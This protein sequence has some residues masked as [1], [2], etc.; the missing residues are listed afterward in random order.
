MSLSRV[1]PHTGKLSGL[2]VASAIALMAGAANAITL[3][4][5]TD[6]NV[7]AGSILGPGITIVGTPTFTGGSNQAATFTGGINPVGF[8]TGIVLMTGDVADIPGPNSTNSS[9]ET[10]GLGGSG[11][12]ADPSVGLAGAGEA[13]L[14]A[15]V[16]TDTHDAAV[17]QFD[18]M[19][20][21]GGGGDLFFNYVFASEEY[22]DF[23]GSSFNDA[24][25]LFVD[26]MNIALLPAPCS[27]AVTINNVNG[28]TNAACYR[29]NV[30]NTNGYPNLGLDTAF[31]GLT[32]V[33]TAS[34]TGLSAG[35]HTIKFAVADTSDE[36]LDSG[37]FIQAGTFANEEIPSTPPTTQIP[38]PGAM[39][40]FAFGLAGLGFARRRRTS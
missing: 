20:T 9:P 38:E 26:G 6:A 25:G 12:P 3:T 4:P 23:V 32:I 35:T 29:N 13:D 1:L 31:D 11:G 19:F 17:L 16:G 33:L 37:V 14:T 21:G 22:I 5:T 24:F 15:L 2:C 34:A 40:L 36:I 28:S 7:L 10:E 30:E 8:D 18:F 27:G 39:A